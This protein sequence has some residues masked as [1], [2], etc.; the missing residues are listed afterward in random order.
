M[1]FLAST[2]KL[3]LNYDESRIEK[4]MGEY[5]MTLYDRHGN[6]DSDVYMTEEQMAELYKALDAHKDKLLNILKHQ[7]E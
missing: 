3:E 1:E 4:D 2:R 6:F 5:C 7:D